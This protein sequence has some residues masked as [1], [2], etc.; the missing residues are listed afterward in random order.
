MI[1]QYR[2]NTLFIITLCMA[3]SLHANQSADDLFFEMPVVLSASR[4]EQPASETPIAVSIIDRQMIEASGARTIPDVLRL[5]PGVIV[6]NS[7]NEFGDEPKIVVAYHG[8]TDQFSRQ[9]QVLIDGRSVYEPM[10]GGVAWNMLPINLEDIERIEFSRGPNAASYGS[11]SF[12]AVINIITRQAIEDQGHL[13]KTSIGNHDIVDATYRFGDSS[14]ELDYRFTLSTQNDDGQDRADGIENHDDV[15]ANAFDYRMDYQ[16]DSRSQLTYQ[17]GYSLTNQQAD[18]NFAPSGIKQARE[19]ENI[20]AYQFLK[21]E[22]SFSNKDSMVI[23]YYYNLLDKDDKSTSRQIDPA[24]LGLPFDAFTLDLDLSIKSERHNLELTHY[25]QVNDDLRLI[26]GLSVQQDLGASSYFLGN[27]NTLRRELYRVFTNM[28]WH[29]TRNDILNFGI[30]VEKNDTIGTD[31]S[32]RLSYTHKFNPRHNIRLGV[33]K[34]IRSPFIIEEHGNLSLTHVLTIGGVPITSPPFPITEL[35][36][37]Q[38]TP[39]SN[40]ENEQI[41]SREIAYYGRFLHDDLL[42]NARIF[43]DRISQLIRLEPVPAAND[44]VPGDGLSQ[45]FVNANSTDVTG[46]ETELDFYADATL[47][48]VAS[49]A[50]LEIKSNDAVYTNS[51]ESFV[52]SAPRKT[53]SLLAIKQFNEKYSGSMGYYY[54]GDFSWIDANS[55]GSNQYRKLDLRLSRNIRMN[56]NKGS[57]SLV[58]QNLLDEYSNYDFDP[59]YGPLI[60]QNLTAYLEFKMLFR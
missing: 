38:L 20:N 13:V 26:W 32:P 51:S 48:I 41:I 12:L 3:P 42:F 43:R 25:S 9:M 60:E 2:L 53:A 6:G 29:V 14:G 18:D 50:Y 46:I 24:D 55:A 8:H 28:E 5:V 7:V 52:K 10:S 19:V 36:D 33:S 16:I 57:V 44:T 1:H 39:V 15:S 4:L 40:L 27:N 47:R 21:Y 11:N 58:L 23:Q 37:Q 56:A 35:V 59:V 34:A 45:V 30:L 22:N 17:G 54:V 31:N 49:A